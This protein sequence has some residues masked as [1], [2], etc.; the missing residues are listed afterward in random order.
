MKKFKKMCCAVSAVLS[1]SLM[2]WPCLGMS[3]IGPI[4][5]NVNI[6]ARGILTS[7]TLSTG[8]GNGSVWASVKN[9]FTLFPSVIIV[10]LELYSSYEYTEAITS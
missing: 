9:N 4:Q 7:L 1:L 6:E 10:Y 3:A 8:G 5:S 2:L